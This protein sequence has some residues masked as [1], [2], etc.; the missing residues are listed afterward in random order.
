MHLSREKTQQQRT[1]GFLKPE[2]ALSVLLALNLYCCFGHALLGAHVTD[3]ETVALGSHMTGA[4]AKKQGSSE[5]ECELCH[6]SKF[7]KAPG[8]LLNSGRTLRGLAGTTNDNGI[9]SLKAKT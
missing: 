5:P 6:V 7:G 3:R 2:P 8:T 1:A 4:K 9:I